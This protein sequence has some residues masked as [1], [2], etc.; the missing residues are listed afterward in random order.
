MR[1]AC[2]LGCVCLALRVGLSAGAVLAVE[3]DHATEEAIPRLPRRNL[4]HVDVLPAIT[5]ALIYGIAYERFNPQKTTSR[6]VGYGYGRN[7]DVQGALSSSDAYEYSSIHAIGIQFR[8]YWA[9]RYNGLFMWHGGSYLRGRYRDKATGATTA[10][11]GAEIQMLGLGLQYVIA[12]RVAL[13]LTGSLR[14][15]AMFV[16]ATEH[17]DRDL[18]SGLGLVLAGGVGIA[19]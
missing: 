19:F 3:P 1:L 17:I 5:G 12:D 13:H 18:T 14:F 8:N 4:V 11:Q 10:V 16:D 6:L 9:P 15:W 7:L 2:L